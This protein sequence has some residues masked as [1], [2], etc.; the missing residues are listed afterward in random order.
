MQWPNLMANSIL[1][2]DEHSLLW[3]RHMFIFKR[4]F[5]SS[6]KALKTW[7][8]FQIYGYLCKY[9][10][11]SESIF[12]KIYVYLHTRNILYKTNGGQFS[13]RKCLRITWRMYVQRI[14]Q[15]EKQYSLMEDGA[16]RKIT[17]CTKARSLMLWY[18]KIY[19]CEGE[20]R[21]GH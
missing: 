16:S 8:F 7:P 11:L 6:V 20:Q 18:W 13:K 10:A 14:V 9:S 19:M 2:K 12:G 21:E 5:V 15:K 17:I 1:K 4:I 3:N